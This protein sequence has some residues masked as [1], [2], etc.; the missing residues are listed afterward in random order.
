MD[1]AFEYDGD[2]SGTEA[3]AL[4]GNLAHLPANLG[5]VTAC[6]FSGRNLGSPGV[7]NS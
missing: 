3:A 4:S 2:T 6:C 5:M 1:L 7:T